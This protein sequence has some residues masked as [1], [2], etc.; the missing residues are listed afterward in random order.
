MLEY[1]IIAA[2]SQGIRHGENNGLNLRSNPCRSIGRNFIKKGLVCPMDCATIRLT[3]THY[4]VQF[5]SLG[6]RKM[7]IIADIA[8]IGTAVAI[9]LF[10]LWML[11]QLF[12]GK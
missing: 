4:R 11:K 7:A 8:S 5:N 9:V 1:W 3:W 6:R 10:S 2:E 12:T